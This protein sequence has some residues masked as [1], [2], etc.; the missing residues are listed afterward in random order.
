[1]KW[2]SGVPRPIPSTAIAP[3]QQTVSELDIDA[4]SR[5]VGVEDVW[6]TEDGNPL[7]PL[8]VDGCNA[9]FNQAGVSPAYTP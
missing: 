2:G 7:R 1:M 8:L 9:I 6:A 4:K 3:W 5:K